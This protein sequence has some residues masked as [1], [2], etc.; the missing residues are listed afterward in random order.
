VFGGGAPA[1][2]AAPLRGGLV[3]A[4][5]AYA[6]TSASGGAQ[7]LNF[8]RLMCLAADTGLLPAAGASLEAWGAAFLFA[9]E[10]GEDVAPG[11]GHLGS[12]GD[13]GG[14]GRGH[15]GLLAQ[16]KL[17]RVGCASRR[18]GGAGCGVGLGVV[19]ADGAPYASSSWPFERGPGSELNRP[20]YVFDS[21]VI[22]RERRDL[23]LHEF[24]VTQRDV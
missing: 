17:G 3:A 20:P 4:A 7:Q 12:D 14:G 18:A 21:E 9:G 23:C 6:A 22:D 5:A 19:G 13:D 2:A 16:V 8:H 1:G 10:A 24:R 15:G 11:L